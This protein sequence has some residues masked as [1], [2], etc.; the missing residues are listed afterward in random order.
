MIV[1][2]A[3]A[4]I[5][6]ALVAVSIGPVPIPASTVLGVITDRIFSSGR[7]DW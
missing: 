3:V 6:A 2:L 4:V 7:G 1:G 5:V